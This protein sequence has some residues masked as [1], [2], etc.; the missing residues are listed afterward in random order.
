M[1]VQGCRIHLHNEFCA[2]GRLA[3]PTQ[4]VGAG[5]G[6][7]VARR[8]SCRNSYV[9]CPRRAS[10]HRGAIGRCRSST[11]YVNF[12]ISARTRSTCRLS[13]KERRA[14]TRRRGR[15][16]GQLVW[17]Q[18]ATLCTLLQPTKLY[19]SENRRVERVAFAFSARTSRWCRRS[20]WAVSEHVLLEKQTP[21]HLRSAHLDDG[22]RPALV[23]S[24]ALRSVGLGGRGSPRREGA[25]SGGRC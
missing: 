23:I 6:S 2:H 20:E 5:S 18:F 17:L 14:G 19:Y 11:T 1:W 22:K 10:G 9:G 3:R 21:D 4:Q 16:A 25:D 7:A 12:C 24:N 8:V 13:R 15:T